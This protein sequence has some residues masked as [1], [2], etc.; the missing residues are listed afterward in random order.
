MGGK[1]TLSVPDPLYIQIMEF[2]K[3]KVNASAEICEL[4]RIGLSYHK[5]QSQGPNIG[6]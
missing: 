6:A 1:I 2:T 3:G 4:I 5:Q